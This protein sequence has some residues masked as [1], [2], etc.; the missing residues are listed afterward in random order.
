MSIHYL[1][2]HV[3]SNSIIDW[4]LP[5]V[6]MSNNLL[7]YACLNFQFDFGEKMTYGLINFVILLC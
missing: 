7:N 2:T 3:I 6:A 4:A 5:I 1:V